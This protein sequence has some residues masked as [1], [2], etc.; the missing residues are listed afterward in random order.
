[1]LCMSHYFYII[2]IHPCI[3]NFYYYDPA[4]SL[5]IFTNIMLKVLYI[6]IYINIILAV[7]MA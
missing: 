2:F 5:P 4:I 3:L 7:F 6:Y 1:M